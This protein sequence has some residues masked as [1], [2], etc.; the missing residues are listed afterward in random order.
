MGLQHGRQRHKVCPLREECTQRSQIGVCVCVHGT[1]PWLQSSSLPFHVDLRKAVRKNF[2]SNTV[3]RVYL[4]QN[5]FTSLCKQSSGPQALGNISFPSQKLPHLPFSKQ[6]IEIWPT[7]AL[8]QFQKSL[9]ASQD[10][11]CFFFYFTFN[12]LCILNDAPL[13]WP[14]LCVPNCFL[15]QLSHFFVIF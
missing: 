10:L 11:A 14:A 3:F 5:K 2:F 8:W 15:M 4:L 7:S 6:A 9:L 13:E 12:N 1:K